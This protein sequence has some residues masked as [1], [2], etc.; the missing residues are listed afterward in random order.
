M[1]KP[2]CTKYF[3]EVRYIVANFVRN[4]ED[5]KKVNMIRISK[6]ISKEKRKG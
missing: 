2:Y 6:F 1:C 5:I 3:H 4:I